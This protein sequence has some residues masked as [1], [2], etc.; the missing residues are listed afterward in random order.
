VGWGLWGFLATRLVAA[1]TFTGVQGDRA[2]ITLGFQVKPKAVQQMLPAPWQLNPLDRGSWQGANF[3]VIF[4]DRIRDE[5]PEGKP[6]YS[7]ATGM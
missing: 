2:R 5:D 7:G 6:K 3:L 1:Q 4:I